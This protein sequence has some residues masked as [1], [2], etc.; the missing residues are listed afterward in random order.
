MSD[1]DLMVVGDLNADVVVK[2][3]D[4]V[5]R[6]G[7][8]EQLVARAELLVG[9]SGAI[10]AHGVA[11]LGPSVGLCA[12]VGD[13]DV[14]RLMTARMTRAGVDVSWV[15]VD[16]D[17]VTGASVI[18]DRAEGRAI[19]TAPGAISALSS[20]DLSNLADRPARHVHIASL[21]LLSPEVREALPD[22]VRRWA[23]SGATT[24]LDTN[25]DPAERWE[26]H[27]LLDLADVVLPNEAELVA[28][29]RAGSVEYALSGWSHGAVVVLKRGER[30]GSV[31]IGGEVTHVGSA[32]GV[33]AVDTTGAGDSFDAGYLTGMLQG[34]DATSAL[35]LA[36]ACGTLS[37]RGLGGTAAQ[38]GLDEARALADV[39]PQP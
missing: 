10:A 35:A 30:G 32:R 4:V 26:T 15:R 7:Q 21:F 8:R 13:D 11:L 3:G 17:L 22:A 31:L 18:L 5:P 27:G 19:L 28:L 38:P 2:G 36:V 29:T 9:G 14:G 39:L 23:A 20:H 33:A 12:T 16:P 37:T 34:M 1:L 25:W 6:F 24:S